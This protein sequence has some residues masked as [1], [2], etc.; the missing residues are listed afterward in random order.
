[1]SAHWKVRS[2]AQVS[3]LCPGGRAR[4][5]EKP[6]RG[7]NGMDTVDRTSGG[8]ADDRGMVRDSLLFG[9]MAEPDT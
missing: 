9:V 6:N 1:M 3:T 2:I 4:S 8:G 7:P 5:K